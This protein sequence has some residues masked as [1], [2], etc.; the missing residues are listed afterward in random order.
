MT[1]SINS[2]VTA[3]GAP[4]HATEVAIQ[5]AV[6]GGMETDLER[7]HGLNIN[8]FNTIT[9]QRGEIESLKSDLEA[10]RAQAHSAWNQLEAFKDRVRDRIIEEAQARDWCEEVNAFLRSVD[11]DPMDFSFT[12]LI[13]VTYR[14]TVPIM[15]PDEQSAEEAVSDEYYDAETIYPLLSRYDE[16]ESIQVLSV[17]AD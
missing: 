9:E 3:E 2:S 7:L 5:R 6:I 4:E 13:E 17:D 16:P 15:A 10:A 1:E 12:A 14:V 11:L 8:Q